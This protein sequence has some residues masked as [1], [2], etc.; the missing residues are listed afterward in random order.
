VAELPELISSMQSLLKTESGARDRK[1]LDGRG[2]GGSQEVGVERSDPKS[3]VAQLDDMVT[4]FRDVLGGTQ[5]IRE[6]TRGLGTFSRV[7]RD[8]LVSVGLNQVLELAVQMARNEIKYRARLVKELGDV[9]KVMGTEGRLSQ[10]FLNLLINATHAIEEGAVEGNE[11]RV[12]T[13]QREGEVFA[14]VKDTGCG[15]PRDHLDR[16]FE[17]FFSTK[18]VGKGSGLGLPISQTI[19]ETCGG[20]ITVESEPGVGTKFTVMLPAAGEVKSKEKPPDA[21]GEAES[22][23]GRILVVDDEEPIR[24]AMERMLS[25]HET[26]GAS[27]GAE[28]KEILEDDAA[29]DLIL[30]DMMMP[31]FSGMDLHKWLRE[32]HPF[33]AQHLIFI[34]GGAFTPKA[35]EYLGSVENNRIEKPFDMKKLIQRV[36]ERVKRSKEARHE[37]GRSDESPQT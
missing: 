16:L 17:P 1:A 30:C 5:R 35:R 37:A 12:S 19:V 36:D 25:H 11:I 15:I 31:E 26:V 21:E 28:A 8:E 9:P 14:Q 33:L 32:A 18:E 22:A 34:T 29:F 24:V 2:A 20:R 27:S 3:I 6:V 4:R 7:E 10:V 23:S 13:W